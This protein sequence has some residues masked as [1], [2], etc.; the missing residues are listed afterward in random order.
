[1]FTFIV[2]STPWQMHYLRENVS[3]PLRLGGNIL[4]EESVAESGA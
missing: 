1:M 3:S 2:S 4:I